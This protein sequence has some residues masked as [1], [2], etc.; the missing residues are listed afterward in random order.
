MFNSDEKP[1]EAGKNMGPNIRWTLQEVG[2]SKLW[3]LCSSK[4]TIGAFL[5]LLLNTISMLIFKN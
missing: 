5:K 3:P 4:S 1:L 2:K